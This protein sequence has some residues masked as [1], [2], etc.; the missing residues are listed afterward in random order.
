MHVNVNDDRMTLLQAGEAALYQYPSSMTSAFRCTA[1]R[2][3]RRRRSLLDSRLTDSSSIGRNKIAA[4][5]AACSAQI[6][7]TPPQKCVCRYYIGLKQYRC[8]PDR[9]AAANSLT[10]TSFASAP[11]FSS[12]A[13][14]LFRLQ[15]C[16][17]RN[18]K[19]HQ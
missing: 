9:V 12:L 18:N 15:F 17:H 13:A 6:D 19:L 4:D 8:A 16:C 1:V 5:R 11:M 2:C 10:T 14:A 7:I 3:R